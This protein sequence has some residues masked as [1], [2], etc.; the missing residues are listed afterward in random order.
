M[1]SRSPANH[2]RCLTQ[3]LNSRPGPARHL[4]DLCLPQRREL[5]F[6]GIFPHR[7]KEKILPHGIGSE[8]H[9][10]MIEG[11]HHHRF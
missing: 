4:L 8:V 9:D 6:A 1:R 10:D 7:L 2:Y 11:S 3:G 5:G